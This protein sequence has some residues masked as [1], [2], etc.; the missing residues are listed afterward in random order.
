MNIPLTKRVSMIELFYDLVFA[1]MISQATSLIHHLSHGV[2]SI[3]S[4]FTFFIVVI[5]FINSWMIQSVFTNRYGESTWTDIAFYFI[6]MMV[7]LYMTNSFS[8]TSFRDMRIFFTAAGILSF[9]LMLQYLIVY[10]K[11]SEIVDKKIAQSYVLILLFRTVTLLIGGLINTYIGNVIAI[12]GVIISWM[13]PMLTGKYAKEHPIIFSHLLER[14]TLLI[15]ITFGETIIGIADYFKPTIFSVYSILIFLIVAAL[16]FTYINEFDHQIEEK[17]T[18]QTGFLLIYLHYL[19]LFGLSLITVSL[20]FI[21][22]R[23]AN[24]VFAISALYGGI[25]LFYLGIAAALH[26][27]LEKFRNQKTLTLL[28]LL[29]TVVGYI[30]CLFFPS[31]GLITVITMIITL[32][33]AALKVSLFY[34]R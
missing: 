11:T 25:F 19:I 13:M 14:L 9:T 32:F 8:A 2:I 3:T 4:L 34:T 18:G 1:Y 6:D 31:F 5:V 12:A 26:Y 29:I 10:F 28:T 16:F 17:R 27:N 21:N 23:E 33:S 15:I 24:T 7:L 20:K 30:L 22:E